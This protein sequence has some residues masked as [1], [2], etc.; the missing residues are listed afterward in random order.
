MPKETFL[1]FDDLISQC[2]DNPEAESEVERR[3]RQDAATLVVDYTDMVKRTDAHGIVYALALARRAQ[4]VMEPAVTGNGGEIIKRVADTWFAVFSSPNEALS[5][6]LEANALMASFNASRTG[7]V[8]DSERNDAIFP[9]AGLGFGSTLVLPR[10]DLYGEEV[11]RAF[12]LG[13]DVATANEILI[14]PAFLRAVGDLPA[15][16]GAHRAPPDRLKEAG[17]EFLVLSDFR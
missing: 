12:V 13:E 6:I 11:N 15:G 14:T 2:L 10:V 3:Y 1:S 8:T 4:E 16:I 7:Q 17:F 9:C 5:A